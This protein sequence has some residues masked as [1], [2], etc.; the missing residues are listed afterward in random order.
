M[1]V[2]N[3]I[4]GAVQRRDMDSLGIA[5]GQECLRIIRPMAKDG[6]GPAYRRLIEKLR[7]IW[8]LDR[9]PLP[10]ILL[11]F[12]V[13]AVTTTSV[14][15]LFGVDVT[16]WNG[17]LSYSGCLALCAVGGSNI[18]TVFRRMFFVTVAIG[19]CIFI[20]GLSVMYTNAD[21]EAYHRPAAMLMAHGWNPVFEATSSA[22]EKYW[23]S[24]AVFNTWHTAYLPRG[25]W[26]FSAVMY[27]MTGFVESGD[28][29]ALILCAVQIGVLWTFVREIFGFSG[30]LRCCAVLLLTFSPAVLGLMFG[31]SCDGAYNSLFIVSLAALTMFVA[32]K[33]VVWLLYP[34]VSFVLMVNIK[35]TGAVASCIMILIFSIP[36]IQ[37][38]NQRRVDKTLIL[39]WFSIMVIS[40]WLAG[41]VGFSPYITNW[42]HHGGPFYP[43]HSFNKKIELVDKITQD[44]EYRNDDAKKM[45]Y[46]GRFCY[47]YISK[48]ATYA[49]Y[50]YTTGNPNFDPVIRVSG[51]VE[52]FGKAFKV[53]FVMSL[54][55]LLCLKTNRIKWALLVIAIS[56][57][58]QPTLY[59]GYA[60]YVPQ[61]A[62][63]P[64][65]VFLNVIADY[66]KRLA[67]PIVGMLVSG[68]LALL[69]WLNIMPLS[70]FALQWVISE[71]NLAIIKAMQSDSEPC[72]WAS[73]Y[74][75]RNSFADYEIK[76][77]TWCDKNYGKNALTGVYPY[78]SYF[79]CYI[80]FSRSEIIPYAKLNHIVSEGDS[81]VIANRNRRNINFFVGEFLP[82]YI[83]RIPSYIVEVQRI[84]WQQL[85]H[86]W[87]NG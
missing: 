69:L 77:I 71:Q 54:I 81:L 15:L 83:Y 79:S 19:G 52:G 5:R 12:P 16:A 6:A 87:H 47:A 11:C 75:S 73:T 21:A 85:I 1:S 22:L 63:F 46:L 37:G 8:D 61:F 60:R 82:I 29:L 53:S 68:Q 49:Y 24:N 74:Y 65:L 58:L 28:S 31:G 57:L 76:N 67:R 72:V 2:N 4:G 38:Y 84:R 10:F 44:F 56:V 3:I 39:R 30:I 66:Q 34:A 13:V 7:G 25:A 33:N 86:A 70:F 42:V 9:L 14:L 50:R 80:Y 40:M 20:A 36:L 78:S 41:V 64:F 26:V 59:C 32:R 17:I 51:G 62:L 45:G 23:M 27:R 55:L 18:A 48:T 35:Y 43:Q